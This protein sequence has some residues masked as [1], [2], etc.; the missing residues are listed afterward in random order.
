M[1]DFSVTNCSNSLSSPS[2]LQ[3]KTLMPQI[4]G[5]KFNLFFSLLSPNENVKK[6]IKAVT[7]NR[8]Y[9]EVLTRKGIKGNLGLQ[10]FRWGMEMEKQDQIVRGLLSIRK[11]QCW[12]ILSLF[13]PLKFHYLF[14]FLFLKRETFVCYWAGR[15]KE[16]LKETRKETLKTID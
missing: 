14:S 3:F 7:N 5:W 15:S 1:Y 12:C 4:V 6:A 16:R 2:W 13:L 9:D 10:W 11:V 8:E